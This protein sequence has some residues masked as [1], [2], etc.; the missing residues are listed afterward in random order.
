MGIAA[1]ENLRKNRCTTKFPEQYFYAESGLHYNYY[2]DYE[3][4]I[5]R[6]V[7]SDP[8]GLR[9][10]VNTYAYT[11]NKPIISF[12][13]YG[14]MSMYELHCIL[15]GRYPAPGLPDLRPCDYYKQICDQT[16]CEY[17]CRWAPIICKTADANPVFKIRGNATTMKLNCIRTCLVREDK[18]NRNRIGEC[19]DCLDDKVID[20][21]HIVCFTQCGVDP[22]IYPGVGPFN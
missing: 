16:G 22:D 10:G 8:I 6:Y 21:Y 3:P 7:Q 14:L 12:D 15:S 20:D 19:D 5:G 9:G 4:S 13:P 17:Y 1:S 2:R 11:E 18:R